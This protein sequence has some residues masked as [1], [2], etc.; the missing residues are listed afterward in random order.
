MSTTPSPSF[1]SLLRKHAT[2][3]STIQLAE[4][5]L[6]TLPSPTEAILEGFVTQDEDTLLL[7]EHVTLLSDIKCNDS[8]F[9]HGETGT[10]KEILAQALHGNRLSNAFVAVNCAAIADTLFESELFGHIKGSFTGAVCDKTGLWEAA[11][12]GTL[13]LDEIGELAPT[14]QA[15]ILRA[16]Q[17]RKIRPVGSTEYK[18]V[19]ARIVCASH[20]DISDKTRF[21]E[22]LYWRLATF[23]L[24]IKPLRHRRGDIKLI[25]HKLLE[26]YSVDVREESWINILEQQDL[27]GNVRELEVL[28][29]RLRMFGKL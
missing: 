1:A 26:S 29:K 13:F 17:T 2:S 4:K 16:I 21:R 8:V 19:N 14:M 5:L 7:K 6:G 9:I 20:V 23:V 24:K 25:V 11:N 10:G 27:F 3:T 28:V 12:N 18:D 15:K 22:D